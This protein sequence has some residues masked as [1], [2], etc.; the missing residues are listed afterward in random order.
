MAQLEN[1]GGLGGTYVSQGDVSVSRSTDGGITWSEPIT[2]MQGT[3]T[4]IGPSNQGV[5]YDKE[6]LTVDNWPSSPFY[7]RAYLVSTKFENGLFGSYGRAPIVLSWSDD[8][9][10]TWTAPKE[11]SGFQHTAPCGIARLPVT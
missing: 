3:G 10:L 1:T 11:I 2:V 6:W 5:F 9:G 7:G 4:G 8:G